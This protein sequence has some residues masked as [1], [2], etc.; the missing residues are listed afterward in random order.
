MASSSQ[1]KIFFKPKRSLGQNFLFEE[2]M[3]RAIAAACSVGGDSKLIEIGPGYGTLTRLLSKNSANTVFAIEKDA[4]LF[5]WLSANLAKEAVDFTMADA[6]EIDWPS[7]LTS[8]QLTVDDEL[9]IVGN[10]PYN[11]SN[12]LLS[13]LLEHHQLFKRMVFLVQKEVGQRWVATPTYYKNKY[14]NLS[15]FISYFC[16]ASL[17]FEVPRGAFKPVPEVDG[18]LVRLEIKKDLPSNFHNKKFFTFVRNCFRFRRKTLYNN[19][20]SF[21]LDQEKARLALKELGYQEKVRPQD[22]SLENYISLFN[23]LFP[24]DNFQ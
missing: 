24:K 4:D 6:L 22:L 7:F 2:K 8:K 20:K 12:H 1:A 23:K 10:L 16:E 21:S 13:N 5:S 18:A 19:I 14:S 11:I 9:I 17:L 15:V 3:L